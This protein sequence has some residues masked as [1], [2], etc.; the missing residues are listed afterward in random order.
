M[1]NFSLVPAGHGTNYTG[2]LTRSIV[3][4]GALILFLAASGM[5]I[6]SIIVPNWLSYDTTTVCALYADRIPADYLRIKELNSIGTS[7]FTDDARIRIFLQV[8]I[9]CS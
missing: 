4:T 8:P 6:A 2:M 5:T 7:A 1:A 3:F 9:I